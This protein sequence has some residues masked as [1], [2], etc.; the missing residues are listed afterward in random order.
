MDKNETN[1]LHMK[2]IAIIVAAGIGS[3]IQNAD[4]KTYVCKQLISLNGKEIVAHTIDKFENSS[5]VDGIILVI[6]KDTK[7]DFSKLQEKYQWKK[8][9]SVVNGGA[10][11]QDSVFCGLEVLPESTEI[12]LV[13]DGVRP[14]VSEKIISNS[15]ITAEKMGACVVG[16]PAKDTIKICN[17]KGLVESTPKRDSL[18]LVQTP[19]TFQKDILLRAYQNAKEKGISGTDD[20]SLVEFMGVDVEVIYGSY[21]NIKI[22]TQEDLFIGGVIAKKGGDK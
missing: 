11:R 10:E 14:F 16:V 15:V 7:E 6:G 20:A 2:R 19:Q 4:A 3:R 13:H 18:W 21:S 12:V 17:E 9:I 22:T 5:K 8:I 1:I